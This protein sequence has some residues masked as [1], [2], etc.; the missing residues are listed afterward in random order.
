[1]SRQQTQIVD[2]PIDLELRELRS[3]APG[4]I[5]NLIHHPIQMIDFLP[6]DFGVF[7]PRIT[8]GE[9]QVQGM[10]EHFHHGQ[11]IADFVGDFRRQQADCGKLFALPQLLLDINNA[12]VEARLFDR[13][14]REFR[15]RGHDPDF[16]IREDVRGAG[17]N[18][19]H[20]GGRSAKEQ[21]NAEQ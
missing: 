8:T 10:E 18:I 9:F 6:H 21:W 17:I 14:R 7:V 16:L 2:E 20:A 19:E 11:R 4:E 13:H 15:Q 12:F 1:V 3:R 5:Q